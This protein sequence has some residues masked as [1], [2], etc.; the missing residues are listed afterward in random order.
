[1]LSATIRPLHTEA[2]DA[3]LLVTLARCRLATTL[4]VAG[5]HV[6]VE[7]DRHGCALFAVL[8]GESARS[9]KGTGA[10]RVQALMGKVDVASQWRDGSVWLRGSAAAGLDHRR[11]RQREPQRSPAAC[12][13]TRNGGAADCRQPG[14]FNLVVDHSQRLQDG[15]PL[16][17]N[18]VKGKKLLGTDYHLSALGHITKSELERLLTSTEQSNGFANRFLWV[19]TC[20]ARRLPHG[21]ALTG[22]ALSQ[23]GLRLRTSVQAATRIGLVTMTDAARKRLGE[24]LRPAHRRCRNSLASADALTSDRGR[25][26]VQCTEIGAALHRARRQPPDR[27]R[28][29]TKRSVEALAGAICEDSVLY[30]WGDMP[31]AVRDVDRLV[32]AV[33]QAGAEGYP[34]ADAYEAVFAKHKRV[35]PIAARAK[36]YGLILQRDAGH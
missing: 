29:P 21:G 36:R 19:H 17:R 5:P 15:Q 25:E 14:R 11:P 30:I 35:G 32:D 24:D 12:R 2:C 28:P 9:R 1:M 26:L 16:R 33:R 20:R 23:V 6:M 8:V 13:R 22:A 3:A 18:R 34:V 10:G 31:P 27:R 4:W 7:S